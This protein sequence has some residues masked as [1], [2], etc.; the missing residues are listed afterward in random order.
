MSAWMSAAAARGSSHVSSGG[1]EPLSKRD[2]GSVVSGEIVPQLPNSR[3]QEIKGIRVERPD[4]MPLS[5][6]IVASDRMT[7]LESSPNPYEK[8]RFNL[9]SGDSSRPAFRNS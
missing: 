1:V 3:Q 4:E 8:S 9:G 6:I 2:I 5:V 7:C